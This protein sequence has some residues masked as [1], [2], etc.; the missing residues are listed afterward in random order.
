VH[1]TVLDALDMAVTTRKPADVVHHSDQ[2]SQYTSVAFLRCKEAGVRP[3]TGSVGDAHDDAMAKAFFATPECELPDRRS[4]RS[5]AKARMA[6]FAFIEG[7]YNPTRRHSAPGCPSPI[8]A[9][10][11]A[12]ND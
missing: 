10:A 11:M 1:P 9:R 2:G 8:E 12:E 3:S 6:V 4:F 7:F 5:Q